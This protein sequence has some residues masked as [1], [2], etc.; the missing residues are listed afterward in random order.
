[1]YSHIEAGSSAARSWWFG[2]DGVR[3]SRELKRRL[4]KTLEQCRF[5]YVLTLCER[6]QLLLGVTRDAGGD[7][8]IGV[9]GQDCLTTA[10]VRLSCKLPQNRP[11]LR[12]LV[13]QR[14]PG[15]IPAEW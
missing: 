15:G 10:A 8:L 14:M 1:V 4:Q 5:A 12:M 2:F 13:R 3:H 9:H 7:E 6:A 11:K